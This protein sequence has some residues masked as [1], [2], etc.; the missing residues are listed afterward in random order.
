MAGIL[1]CVALPVL[2]ALNSS[3]LQRRIIM[4]GIA[5]LQRA[6][7]LRVTI[8]SYRWN[9]RSSIYLTGVKIESAG[10]PVL[11]CQNVRLDYSFSLERPYLIVNNIELQKPFLQLERGPGGAWLLPFSMASGSAHAS[12]S[13]PSTSCTGF[14]FPR[15]TIL[16]GRIK[17]VQQGNTVLSIRDFS[18]AINLRMIAKAGEHKIEMELRKIHAAVPTPR[19]ASWDEE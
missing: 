1:L 9:L 19:F 14:K 5:R 16:A 17:A 7:H 2:I 4:G 11:D 3:S 12:V 6:T 18:G 8:C 15:I 10:K 13:R